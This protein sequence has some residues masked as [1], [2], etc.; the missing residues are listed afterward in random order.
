M[1]LV[2]LPGTGFITFSYWKNNPIWGEKDS[3]ISYK[4]FLLNYF[5]I[6]NLDKCLVERINKTD[7][8]RFVDSGGFQQFTMGINLNPKD[9]VLI[10]QKIGQY[11]VILD[12]P[13]YHF[14]KREAPKFDLENFDKYLEKTIRNT[15]IMVDNLWRKDFKLY[16]VV[17]GLDPTLQI[18]WYESLK[19]EFDF[20]GWC[21]TIKPTNELA[22][23]KMILLA[24]YL[25]IRNLHIL[26][27]G[28]Y[29]GIILLY[30]LKSIFDDK[31]DLV[32]YDSTTCYMKAKN[33]IY[34]FING[35]R[36]DNIYVGCKSKCR[37]TKKI[38]VC[39]C[40]VCRSINTMIFQTPTIEGTEFLA[41]HNMNILF[42]YI[43]KTERKESKYNNFRVEKLVSD[44][45]KDK[46]MIMNFKTSRLVKLF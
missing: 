33:R 3:Y 2:Y 25:G 15:K 35:N 41:Q 32:T 37:E 28:G 40:N 18:K 29:T 21:I 22:I 5:Y 9:V 8:I 44:Y 30:Y 42:E 1:N 24:D 17:Q 13:P 20:Y 11:G 43:N 26:G 6:K 31:F 36:I 23:T 38:P 39:N 12:C 7:G 4:H 45:K 14:R 34:S 27:V 10:Q 19:K 16:G 46:S